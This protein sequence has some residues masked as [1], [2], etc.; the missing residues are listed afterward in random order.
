MRANPKAYGIDWE[1]KTDDPK[2]VQ[3]RR[4][5]AMQ[6]SRTLQQ[7]QMIIFN[8]TTEELRSK[9]IGRIASQY[10]INKRASRL[11]TR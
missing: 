5:L 7:S 3:R 2:L 4:A 10:Y 6:A 8:E 9:D 1:E 11:S